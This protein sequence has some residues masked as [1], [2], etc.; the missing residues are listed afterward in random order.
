M[1]KQQLSDQSSDSDLL[2]LSGNGN[3]DA[4]LLLYR[5]H[6]GAVFRFALH[7]SGSPEIAEEVTQEVFLAMLAEKQRYIAER[8]SLECYLIGV[9]RNHVRRQLRAVRPVAA[10]QREAVASQL[11]KAGILDELCKKQELRALQ[12]AILRLPPKYREVV[13]LCDLEGLSYAQAAQQLTCSVGTVRSRLHRA[14]NL[15]EAKFRRDEKL[16]MREGCSV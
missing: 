10:E 8:G 9:A 11:P 13:A 15:L 14:R 4:F 3:E 12:I 6:Q 5:R 16:R 2:R 1:R 7:M